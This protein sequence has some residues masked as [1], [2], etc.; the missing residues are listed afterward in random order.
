[1]RLEIMQSFPNIE[2]SYD[3]MTHKKVF[4]CDFA[5]AI[6][7]GK[8]MFAW[9]RKYNGNNVCVFVEDLT[10]QTVRIEACSS[11]V[12]CQGTILHGT[13]VKTPSYELFAVE[14]VFCLAGESSISHRPMDSKLRLLATQFFCDAHVDNVVFG[15]PVI[16]PKFC[17]EMNA[18]IQEL[19][20]KI[21]CIQFYCRDRPKNHYT[22]KYQYRQSNQIQSQNRT[23]IN[24]NININI[25]TNSKVEPKERVEK[26]SNS[27][28][29][30]LR[31]KPDL[32]NDIYH[33]YALDQQ[34]GQEYRHSVAHIPDYK[35]SVMMNGLFR[36][37]KEN[38]N[39]DTLEESD[40]EEE[41]ENENIDKFV[42]LK[43]SFI[44]DC[45]YNHKFKKWIPVK[46]T[47]N[48]STV[49]LATNNDLF[50]LEKNKY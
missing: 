17:Q 50:R 4:S 47:A 46:L 23:N 48:N 33:L 35:T 16:Y 9:F 11:E 10:S 37:I 29:T 6:P 31:V 41:Y 38:V 5:F 27:Y 30:V 42:D 45:Y 24:T 12:L 21:S 43:K 32:Q 49:R 44:M 20:Y 28:Y 1:M 36:N 2:L 34:S 13:Y 39:L 18:E 3:T 7:E 25:N 26:S 15:L 19:P 14:N 22:M 40:D 8:K